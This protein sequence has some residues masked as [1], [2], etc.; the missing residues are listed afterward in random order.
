MTFARQRNRLTMP[1]PQRIRIVNQH[2]TAQNPPPG[3]ERPARAMGGPRGT[4]QMVSSDPKALG[5]LMRTSAPSSRSYAHN[6]HV[7]NIMHT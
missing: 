2:G 4:S 5:N 6:L 3:T 7:D 1:F